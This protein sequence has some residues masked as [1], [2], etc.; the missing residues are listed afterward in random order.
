MFQKDRTRRKIIPPIDLIEYK[1]VE[2]I[3]NG[4]LHIKQQKS[5]PLGDDT[6]AFDSS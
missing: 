5:D 6:F 3:R 1:V 2:D 4:K